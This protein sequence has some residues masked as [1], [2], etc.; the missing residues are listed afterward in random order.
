MNYMIYQKKLCCWFGKR[1]KLFLNLFTM[2]LVLKKAE[3]PLRCHNQ[4]NKGVIS[5]TFESFSFL[6]LMVCLVFQSFLCVT[7]R[8]RTLF[9]KMNHIWFWLLGKVP[10]IINKKNNVG[11]GNT[12]TKIKQFCVYGENAERKGEI[13][14]VQ[15]KHKSLLTVL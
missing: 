14:R 2:N 6:T 8:T 10:E 15:L 7:L 5:F 1:I 9:G 12:G 4:G 11:V 13:E 3:V